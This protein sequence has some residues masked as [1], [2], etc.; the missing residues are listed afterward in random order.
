MI[1]SGQN[2]SC[3]ITEG[4]LYCWGN[5]EY[6]Q[7]GL[8]NFDN[9]TTMQQ[10]GDATNWSSIHLGYNSSCGIRDG[11]LYCWGNNLFNKLGIIGERSYNSPQKIEGSSWSSVSVGETHSCGIKSGKLY[12][13]GL[14]EYG[15][16]GFG[17]D[18]EDEDVD[19][20]TGRPMEEVGSDTNWQKVAVAL[21]TSC[22]IKSGGKLYCWGSNNAGALGVNSNKSKYSSPQRVGKSENWQDIDMNGGADEEDYYPIVCGIDSGKLYCWG[23]SEYGKLGT[24]DDI[25]QDSP[26]RVG[27]ADNWSSVKLG[28]THG[29][30][31]A[32]GSLYCWGN[33]SSG[34]L[35]F[36][37]SEDEYN[38]EYPKKIENFSN[39]KNV[40][41]G[42][43]H[44]CGLKD[45]SLYCWGKN[46]YGE[47]AL[48]DN[49]TRYEPTVVNK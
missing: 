15:E 34:Q 21:Y 29:C 18:D 13:W 3:G 14:N 47:L 16:L 19:E 44:N 24:G 20:L 9:Q 4:K 35:G 38:H 45:D 27:N 17:Y 42:G 2:H 28:E 39:W 41:S 46:N 12:C 48:G 5:N 1:S 31:I 25:E 30:A 36:K 22:G 49:E 40:S 37:N 7:L 10:V 8:G 11:D 23:S 32:D 43:D 26:Q 6:G 33:N